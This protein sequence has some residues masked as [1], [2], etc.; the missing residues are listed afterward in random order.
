MSIK[1]NENATEIFDNLYKLILTHT[2]ETKEAKLRDIENLEAIFMEL[3]DD[4]T[5]QLNT[6][7]RIKS[8]L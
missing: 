7:L 1:F 3:K 4:R 5:A 2:Y 6:V 8:S